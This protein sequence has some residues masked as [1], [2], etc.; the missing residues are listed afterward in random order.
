MQ[1]IYSRPPKNDVLYFDATL[2]TLRAKQ[3]SKGFQ[4]KIRP[5]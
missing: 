5:N 1:Q 3:K 4:N 2:K